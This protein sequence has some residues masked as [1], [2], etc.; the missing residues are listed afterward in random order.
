MKIK[1]QSNGINI[2]AYINTDELEKQLLT[3][4]KEKI[5]VLESQLKKRNWYIKNMHFQ[6]KRRKWL[7][8]IGYISNNTFKPLPKLLTH[9]RLLILF[10]MYER[11]FTSILKMKK[12]L[13][14]LGVPIKNIYT[15]FKYLVGS[16]LVSKDKR[17]FYFIMDKGREFVEYYEN[18]MKVKFWHMA[19]IKQDISQ[20]K[21]E[22]NQVKRE[23][24]YPKE[25]LDARRKT[26][27]KLMTP[28]WEQGYKKLP[29]DA[30]KR[31]DLLVKW[32][33]ER[34]VQD[35]W[36]TKLIFNWGSK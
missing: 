18:N 12:D 21:G 6:L 27:V 22:P 16:G 10:Y 30:F 23:N 31:I 25:E 8:Y 29:K 36:Y 24:K 17:D 1:S 13:A 11:E 35:E 34:D 7:M 3:P 33:K 4:Y 19:K 5:K 9:K 14:E 26:Y 2:S 20:I 15:D 28:F 32:M